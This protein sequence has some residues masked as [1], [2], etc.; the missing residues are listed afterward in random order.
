MLRDLY[1]PTD[2]HH[3]N[4]V[5]GGVFPTL[6]QYKLLTLSS[7]SNLRVPVDPRRSDAK[8]DDKNSNE[9]QVMLNVKNFRPDE[10]VVKVVNNFL[11]IRG[12]HEEQADEY[13]FVA[14][15]F[16]RRY[17]LPD[18]VESLTMTSS[19]RENGVLPFKPPEKRTKELF[20]LQSEASSCHGGL[21]APS[22]KA[23]FQAAKAVNN[24]LFA[25]FLNYFIFS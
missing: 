22:C 8:K 2:C 21:K 19:L 9:Y 23:K 12:K 24:G 25:V 14:R 4:I 16:T 5:P 3:H 1:E 11:V 10:I 17:Q 7:I 15:E 18:E 6:V 13:G 20:L